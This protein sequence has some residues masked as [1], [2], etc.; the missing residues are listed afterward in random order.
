MKAI[1]TGEIDFIKLA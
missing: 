1:L